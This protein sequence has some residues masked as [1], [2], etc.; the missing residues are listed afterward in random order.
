MAA[1]ISDSRQGI[2]LI[3][4]ET[5]KEVHDIES[6]DIEYGPYFKRSKSNQVQSNDTGSLIKFAV[7]FLVVIVAIF[8]PIV[9]DVFGV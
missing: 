1:I 7:I 5:S 8:F 6:Y 2:E 4:Y 3:D 9:N